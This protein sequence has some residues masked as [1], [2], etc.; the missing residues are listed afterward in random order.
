[1]PDDAS[2]R[3]RSRRLAYSIAPG[4]LLAGV[5]G[6]IAF[7]VIPLL[8]VRVGLPLWFIGTILAANR[9]GR[10][11]SAPIVGVLTDRWGGR[12]MVIVDLASTPYFVCAGVLSVVLPVA[13]WLARLERRAAR[14]AAGQAS[15]LNA[16][17]VD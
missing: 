3:A 6:G 7:P 2:D 14:P 10:I 16:P 17:T 9:A 15:L 1:M 12:R 13:V 5:A 11:V 8:G 4:V